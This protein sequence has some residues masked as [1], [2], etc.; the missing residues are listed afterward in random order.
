MTIK[1]VERI[2]GITSANIRFYEREQLITPTRNHA[3]N[4]REYSEKDVERLKQIKFLRI[5]GVSINEIKKLMEGECRLEEVIEQQRQKLD[6]EAEHIRELQD[7]CTQILE[8]KLELNQLDS[9]W[10]NEDSK[11]VRT[12]LNKILSE[13]TS[14]QEITQKEYNRYIWKWLITAFL[15]DT[16]ICLIFPNI[17]IQ[18]D[19]LPISLLL[20][21]AFVTG[22]ATVW[23]AKLGALYVNFFVASAMLPLILS[24]FQA[25][26]KREPCKPYI[27]NAGFFIAVVVYTMLLGICIDRFERIKKNCAYVLAGASLFAAVMAGIF[28]MTTQNWLFCAVC[29][30]LFLIY[31]SMNWVMSNR[32]KSVFTKFT[33]IVTAINIV[34]LV[35]MMISG[36]GNTKSWRRDGRE[37]S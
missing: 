12:R 11:V 23:T 20:I 36:Y 21:A 8:K 10:L 1:E 32:F 4:Y 5:L 7:V 13:D 22:I 17:R 18:P 29:L 35:G 30:W 2:V 19:G 31:I 6:S 28:Y 25:I 33:G 16:L 24:L 27:E 14:G 34:N 37:F 9:S 3:N 15:M 26:T